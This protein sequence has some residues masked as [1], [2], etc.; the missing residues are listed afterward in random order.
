MHFLQDGFR[1]ASKKVEVENLDFICQKRSN[2]LELVCKLDK[3]EIGMTEWTER[4]PDEEGWY[5][6]W[7]GRN[8]GTGRL[9]INSAGPVKTLVC[10]NGD[11]APVFNGRLFNGWQIGSRISAS[12]A[13]AG[14]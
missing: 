9:Q 2:L 1:S 10:F 4:L 11:R 8:M 7:N 13:P 14:S 6:V 5:W 3:E 12:D